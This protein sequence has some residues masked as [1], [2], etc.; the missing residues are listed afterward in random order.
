MKNTGL[1]S[2]DTS[3]IRVLQGHFKGEFNLAS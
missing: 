2:K 3:L 1:G